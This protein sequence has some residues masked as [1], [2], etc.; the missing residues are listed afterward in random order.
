MGLS[1][2]VWPA[3]VA[4]L[5][6]VTRISRASDWYQTNVAMLRSVWASGYLS[7]V[8]ADWRPSASTVVAAAAAARSGQPL[9][10]NGGRVM[11]SYTREWVQNVGARVRSW[12]IVG[13]DA[14]Q[15]DL[16]DRVLR[17]AVGPVVAAPP[18]PADVPTGTITIG[19]VPSSVYL[20]RPFVLSGV[21]GGGD[22]GDPVVV[23]VQRPGS[24]RWSYSSTRLTYGSNGSWWYRY[25]PKVRGVYRFKSTFAGDAVVP[26]CTSRIIGVSVR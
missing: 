16:A 10:L 11:S 15:P 5:P 20:P 24:A 13:T 8:V 1:T 14:E 12:T 21:L 4:T 3:A 6:R 22:A 25:T 23:M 2:S 18:A 17:K 9:V 26:A 19:A 7:P